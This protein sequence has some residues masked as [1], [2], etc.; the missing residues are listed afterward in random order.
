[1]VIFTA[2]DKNGLMESENILKELWDGVLTPWPKCWMWLKD[3]LVFLPEYLN[4]I[5]EFKYL[6]FTILKPLNWIIKSSNCSPQC[7]IF[8]KTG[9]ECC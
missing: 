2:D 1:M 7:T 8:I 3:K 6:S 5:K 9:Q 4:T